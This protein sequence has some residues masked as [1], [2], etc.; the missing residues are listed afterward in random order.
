MELSVASSLMSRDTREIERRVE[1]CCGLVVPRPLVE[2]PPK[3]G[4]G[5]TSIHGHDAKGSIPNGNSA[6][7]SGT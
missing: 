2:L 7:L 1:G 3:F 6:R 4:H 5:C